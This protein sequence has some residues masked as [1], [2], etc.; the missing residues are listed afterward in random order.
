MRRALAALGLISASMLGCAAPGPTPPAPRT[1]QLSIP[2]GAYPRAFAAARQTLRE[3]DFLI[4]RADAA[5]GVISS[6]PKESAGLA[7][8]W[9]QEQSSPRQELDDLFNRQSRQ[10]RVTFEPAA[11][12]RVSP[13]LRDDPGALVARVRV[14]LFRRQRPGW[15]LEPSSIRLNSISMDN[16]LAARGLEPT[17]N[18][19]IE[20]DPDLESR[21]LEAIQRTM[22]LSQAASVPAVPR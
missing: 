7:T 6:R 4:E 11:P 12:A 3:N 2:P 18:V 16:D 22:D 5:L 14:T 21:M 1:E 13:D 20:T 8:P 15:R 19:A 17:Y 10:I 9:D